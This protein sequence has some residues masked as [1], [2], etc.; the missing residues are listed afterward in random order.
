MEAFEVQARGELQLGLLIGLALKI[1]TPPFPPHI[2][3]QQLPGYSAKF[4]CP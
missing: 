2:P 1:T 3:L 4:P